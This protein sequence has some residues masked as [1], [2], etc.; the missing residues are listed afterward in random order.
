MD[1][2]PDA[3]SQEVA[4]LAVHLYAEIVPEHGGA[5][6]HVHRE[7]LSKR[8]RLITHDHSNTKIPHLGIFRNGA[9]AG[10]RLRESPYHQSQSITREREIVGQYRRASCPAHKLGPKDKEVLHLTHCAVNKCP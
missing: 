4:L 7:L 5:V 2:E 9:R 6:Q 1:A 8:V 3:H 10:K